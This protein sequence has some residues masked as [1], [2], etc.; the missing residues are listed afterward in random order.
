MDLRTR[1]AALAPELV[2]LRRELHRHPE[3]G[4]DLPRTQ[5]VVLEA[6]AGHG[7]ELGTGRGLSSV[8][9][10]V[11]G[12][13]PGPTVL[14]RADMD[15]LPITELTGLPYAADNGA[16]HACGHD[17]HVA[18]LVGA[19][20]LLADRRDRIAGSVVV[21][22]QPGEESGGGA[23]HMLDEGLLEVTGEHPVAAYGL[24][25]VP[26]PAGTFT[27]R[28]GAV[29][30]GASVLEITVRGR[31]GHGSTPQQA[32]DPVPALAQIILALQDL[33]AHRFPPRAP[34]VISVTVLSAGQASN[35]IND[36]ATLRATVRTVARDSI[37]VLRAELPG[38][39]GGIA[40][41]HRCT[42]EIDLRVGYPVTVNDD[43]LAR[44][45]LAVLG[46]LFGADRAVRRDH[47]LMA[48]EDFSYV[49]ERVP[50]AFLLLGATPP[51]LDPDTAE[52]N[53]SPRAVFDDAVLADGAAA[54]A[55]LAL[56]HVGAR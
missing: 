44:R 17:L 4:L 22:F 29:M 41:A 19:T 7:V 27:T 18:G 39:V 20:R 40:A 5:R 53:H 45:S 6:L 23:V 30:A 37:D 46:E 12:A 10:V 3:L 56:S 16:M 38:L 52:F 43:D 9:G 28:P 42:A 26:G 48:S 55:A 33:A 13:R 24:H 49:L 21:M 50:G 31:G 36:T 32:V 47:P 2:A 34:V 51:G 15:A 8:V 1:A 14:L 35:I 25:V 54:L 11:R